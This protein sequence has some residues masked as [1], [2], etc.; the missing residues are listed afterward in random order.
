MNSYYSFTYFEHTL[1]NLKIIMRFIILILLTA[2]ISQ[3][4]DTI[5]LNFERKVVQSSSTEITKGIAYY[6]SPNRLF[7]E[8]KQPIKQIMIIEKNM[9]TIYYPEDNKAF[10]IKS[11]KSFT[12]P[13]INSIITAIKEDYGL[14]ELGYNLVKHEKKDSKIYTYWDPPKDKRKILGQF[15]IA[16]E[17][18]CLV[19]AELKSYEG[20]T[21]AK[22][23]YQNHVKIDGRLFPMKVNSEI[24]EGTSVIEEQITYSEVKFNVA[25]PK[26]ITNFRIP[27]SVKIENMEL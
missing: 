12:M 19:Y 2:L 17:N 22:S 6:K 3:S 10:C 1:A 15:I 21:I 20:K 8:V 14:A 24:M 23:F 25:I 5:F 16:S 7:I 27:N 4:P 18:N 26:E 9:L 11:K 13:F